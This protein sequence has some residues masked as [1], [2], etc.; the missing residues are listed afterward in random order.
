[1]LCLT[2]G[3]LGQTDRDTKRADINE[4]AGVAQWRNAAAQ[5]CGSR[6]PIIVKL[7]TLLCVG[8]DPLDTCNGYH[9]AA[10]HAS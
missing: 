10:D 2:A 6:L 9:G 3:S 8:S 5:A 1:M 4:G 7:S